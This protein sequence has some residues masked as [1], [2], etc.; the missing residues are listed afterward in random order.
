MRISKSLFTI[1][2]PF[3]IFGLGGGIRAVAACLFIFSPRIVAV[4]FIKDAMAAP[5][6]KITRKVIEGGVK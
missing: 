6:P 2:Y 4:I 1:D 5:T 3:S